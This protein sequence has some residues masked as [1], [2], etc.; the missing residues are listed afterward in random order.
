M[1]DTILRSTNVEYIVPQTR[2]EYCAVNPVI[3][4]LRYILSE[5]LLICCKSR[6]RIAPLMI[7]LQIG[8]SIQKEILDH[9]FPFNRTV[10]R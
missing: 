7:L 8:N 3:P 9:G 1:W 4:P 6:F 5:H 10:E 2:A